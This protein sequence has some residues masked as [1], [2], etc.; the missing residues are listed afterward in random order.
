VIVI[1]IVI[2]I[3]T[4]N[5]RKTIIEKTVQMMK[6][7]NHAINI[8]IGKEETLAINI[9]IGKEETLAINIVIGKEETLAINIVIGKEETLAI[10]IVNGKGKTH[11][12]RIINVKKKNVIIKIM[13]RMKNVSAID[14]VV[15][16]KLT[17][18][19]EKKE[20]KKRISKKVRFRSLK[21]V[22]S[23]NLYSDKSGTL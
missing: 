12:I 4:K 16:T 9:V 13:I 7:I 19:Q 1:L 5:V 20:R 15:N 14:L 2:L 21:S 22:K 3:S 8:V 23:Q 17:L 11:V 18:N 10:K 6:I